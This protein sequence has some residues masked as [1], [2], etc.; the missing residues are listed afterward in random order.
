MVRFSPEGELW[1]GTTFGLA[2]LDESLGQVGEIGR[3]VVVSLPA[4]FGPNITTMEFDSRGN[5][6]LGSLNG[7]AR[8]EASFDSFEH[9][10][11]LNSGLV[12]DTIRSL[13]LDSL[14]GDLWISTPAGVSVLRSA[15]GVLTRNLES[16]LA[17][18]NPFVIRNDTERLQFNIAG[19]YKA[20]VFTVAGELVWE[21]SELSDRSW[22]GRNQSGN[23]VASGVYL[24]VLE[25][26]DGDVARGKF[27]L[28][29]E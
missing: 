27:L 15:T 18:P 25:D 6:W 5:V 16:V 11:T 7:L 19:K 23:P 1:T 14:T 13:T 29:R 26:A 21:V 9:F 12:S 17:Y 10:T 24:F 2:R 22:D 28:V 20:R 8:Y 4:G 3:F